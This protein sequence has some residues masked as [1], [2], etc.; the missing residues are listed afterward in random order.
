MGRKEIALRKRT[1]WIVGGVVGVLV[2]TGAV[3]AVVIASVQPVP[4]EATVPTAIA[5]RADI[6]STV[7]G[8][9]ALAAAST[10]SA[11]FTAGGTV[12]GISVA[13]GQ[14]V[15]A[16][17]DLATIDPSAADREL[18]K[19]R[20]AYAAADVAVD[21][22]RATPRVPVMRSKRRESRLPG[23]SNR[24]RPRPQK[25]RR[26]TV[27]RGLPLLSRPSATRNLR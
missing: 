19:A 1:Y 23:L 5:K 27:P 8:K 7:R 26:M 3:A 21:G 22:A 15:S 11:S 9:G 24:F 20:G 6:V 12:T 2:A 17:Q 18:E 13:L 4:L 10:A 14:S 25:E 16:G